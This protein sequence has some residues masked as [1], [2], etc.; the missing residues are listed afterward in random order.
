MH[1]YICERCKKEKDCSITGC[2][3]ECMK[4]CIKCTKEKYLDKKET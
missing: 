3:G 4:Q 1:K 2:K